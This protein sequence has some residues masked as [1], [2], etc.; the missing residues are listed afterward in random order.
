[1]RTCCSSWSTGCN[2]VYISAGRVW[3]LKDI[4]KLLYKGGEEKRSV[5]PEKLDKLREKA[6]SWVYGWL[7]LVQEKRNTKQLK[8]KAGPQGA[9][10]GMGIVCSAW[11]GGEGGRPRVCKNF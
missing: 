8:T 3:G 10:S 9:A 1:M 7:G 2:D 6:K 11:R 5:R 4:G